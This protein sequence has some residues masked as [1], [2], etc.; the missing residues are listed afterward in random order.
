MERKLILEKFLQNI[1]LSIGLAN[2][3]I[4]I[5]LDVAAYENLQLSVLYI[6]TE[7]Y[8]LL[9]KGHWLWL[10][11]LPIKLKYCNALGMA[12]MECIAG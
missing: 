6:N 5:Q 2:S 3:E 9:K 10:T 12:M 8:K 11:S 4:H 1:V 7:N